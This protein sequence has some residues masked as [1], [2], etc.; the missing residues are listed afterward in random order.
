MIEYMQT[1]EET[2][3]EPS[4]TDST[5]GDPHLVMLSVDAMNRYII[6]PKFMQLQVEYKGKNVAHGRFRELMLL[7]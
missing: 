5:S 3:S 2:D 7:H 1:S 6:A 4:E